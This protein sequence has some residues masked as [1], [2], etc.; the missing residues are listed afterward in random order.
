MSRPA[1]VGR[2]LLGFL[3]ALVLIAAGI[4]V[5]CGQAQAHASLVRAEPADGGMVASAPASFALSFNEPVSPLVLR[6][7]QPDGTSLALDRYVLREATLEIMAPAGLGTGT[8][9]LSWRV[10]SED[11]HPVGGSVIFSIGAPSA[12]P[13]APAAET[14]FSVRLAI[15][16]AKV[17]LYL[18]LFFGVGGA[19]ALAWFAP[20]TQHRRAFI[21]AMLALGLPGTI[22]S[23]GLQGVDALEATFAGLGQAVIWRTGYSTSIGSTAAVAFLALAL[24]TGSLLLRGSLPA[25]LL[26]L[27]ALLA[28]GLALAASGH[29]SAAPP[30][31]L[32]RLS[33]FLHGVGITVW[34][35]ALVPLLLLFAR[36]SPEAAP[37]LRRFSLAIPYA[38]LPLAAAGIILAVIQ[39]EHPYDIWTTAYGQVLLVKLVLVAA[40]FALATLNRFWLTGPAERGE[41]QATDHLRRSLRAEIALVVAIFAVAAL[42]RFTPPPRALA[43]A[44]A[45]PA[46]VHIHTLKAMADLTITPGRVGAAEAQIV[47]M[48]GD[49]GPLDAKEVTLVLA[50]TARGIEPFRRPATRRDGIWHV[51]NLVLPAPGIWSVRID[52][53]IS[54]FDMA[55]LEEKIDIRP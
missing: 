42:W 18:G 52:V 25:R 50:N 44:A 7:V 2:P 14:D 30:Q 15:W 36:R 49:F 23:V 53:L 43:L 28:V 13:A 35:G 47:L 4:V 33:V 26:S 32:T 39:L 11:G 1:F 24:A 22:F 6:L 12:A 21:F 20:G 31:W 17:A 51:D 10:I 5:G 9:V 34:A 27:A 45:Q 37:A 38:V 41:P 19:F 46:Q 48:T 54:D 55:R 29:A 16:T 8:H 40:L 3:A